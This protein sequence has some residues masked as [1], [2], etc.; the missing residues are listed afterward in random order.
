LSIFVKKIVVPLL[1]LT[2][3]KLILLNFSVF[4]KK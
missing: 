2:I 4:W 1:Q 3:L